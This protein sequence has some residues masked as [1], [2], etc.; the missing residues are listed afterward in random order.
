MTQNIIN[1]FPK[2]KATSK[3]DETA[4]EYRQRAIEYH[5]A[6]LK[7]IEEGIGEDVE[8][9]HEECISGQKE[10]CEICLGRTITNDERQR[11]KQLIHQ[12]LIK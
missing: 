2:I 3:G 6:T 10:M 9:K 8:L 7:E 5:N 11:I 4:Y 1:G 12:K